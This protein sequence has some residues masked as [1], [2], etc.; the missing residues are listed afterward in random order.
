[1]THTP[2][3]P[4]LISDHASPETRVC[5][6]VPA[7][8]EALLLP[9][10]LDALRLQRDLRGD[11]LAS[12]TYEVILL[13][14]NCTDASQAIAERYQ[15][16]YPDFCLH[17][18]ACTLPSVQSHAGTA[19]RL[20]MDT[21]WH[22][23]QCTSHEYAA[24][25]STDADTVVATDWI[26]RNLAAIE[27]G[28]E[29]VGGVINLFPEDAEALRRNA[30]GTWTAY[31][32]DR[33]LQCLVAELESI[34]DPDAS[35]PWPRHLQHFGAS[36]ACTPEIYARSG[37][38]PP[39]KCLEDAA[40]IDEL[41]K[42]DARIRHCPDTH[43]Y[44]SARLDGRAQVGLSGQLR[45]WQMQSENHKPHFVD[46]AEW[47]E[48]RFRSIAALR[49]IHEAKSLPSLENYPKQWRSRIADIHAERLTGPRFLEL[50]DCDSL[51][52]EMF[53]QPRR[54]EIT[55]TISSLAAMLTRHR[56]YRAT[57]SHLEHLAVMEAVG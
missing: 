20:L 22:R 29:V 55:K 8:N 24:I 1:M 16:T 57:P 41:R 27:D 4:P 30:P 12:A 48:H 49:R 37:G 15:R 56:R 33:L 42:V 45:L 50:L 9:R 7:R 10:T 2:L 54:T 52:E 46:S 28:A 36:L 38:L 21:A 51:I 43:I 44:T 39:V 6:I 3:A 18:A 53:T 5:V 11:R 31:Q 26:A 23:L 47:T 25:L 35:D 14:N 19:R 17:I 34:L 13:L 32:R 40:F